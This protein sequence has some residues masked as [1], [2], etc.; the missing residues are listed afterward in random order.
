MK[1]KQY[2][3][4]GVRNVKSFVVNKASSFIPSG[5]FSPSGLISSWGG[6]KLNNA[7]EEA[8]NAA[9]IQKMMKKSPFENKVGDSSPEPKSDPLGFYHVQY[10]PELTGETMGNW[11]LFF[12]ITNNVGDN[13]AFGS[14]FNYAETIGAIPKGMNPN[15]RASNPTQLLRL[16][17]YD[18]I[19]QQ[20]LAEG[21]DV[22]KIRMTNTVSTTA[23][24]LGWKGSKPSVDMVSG[25]IALYMPNDIKVSY[26]ADWGPEDTNISGDLSAAFKEMNNSEKEGYEFIEDMLKHATGTVVKGLKEIVGHTAAGAG[27]GDW[28]KIASKNLGF[29]INNH[30]EMFYEGP[31]FRT[32]NYNFMFW[33][34]NSDET[35]RVQKIIK[36]FKYHMHPWKRTDWGSRFFQYPS[37]FEIHYL[38]DKGVNTSLH[39]ISRC[40]LTKVDV[41]YGPEGGNYKTFKDHSPVSYKVDLSFK[42]LEY[43]TKQTIADGKM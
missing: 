33:P 24:D 16:S 32:F 17:N 15:S 34:R 6:P 21:I 20:Y 4:Q 5:A 10:P 23:Q 14:D 8:K 43:Q 38:A 39:R 28:F 9:A 35:D 2:L 7:L 11:I 30:R 37:E 31:E 13:P 19:R 22:D 3:N 29:A 18:A 27:I 42:E 26:G 36:M 41:T 25:A 40:A 1:I 12:A